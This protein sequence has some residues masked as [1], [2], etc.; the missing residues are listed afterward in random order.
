MRK[1]CIRRFKQYIPEA[2]DPELQED[3]DVTELELV[4]PDNE[5]K[6]YYTEEQIK[7]AEFDLE[8]PGDKDYERFQKYKKECEEKE[9]AKEAQKLLKNN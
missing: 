3:S 4:E 7:E 9:R 6:V 1:D 5:G 8:F 2:N